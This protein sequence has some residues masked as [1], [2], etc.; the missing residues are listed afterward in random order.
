[1]LGNYKVALAMIG[2]FAFGA[3][4]QSLNAQ[5][6]PPAYGMLK[7]TSR[8]GR[9]LKHNF[10]LLLSKPWRRPVVVTLFEA[11]RQLLFKNCHLNRGS[12]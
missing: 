4:G 6:R 1:M 12:L 11:E 9:N 3:V 8:N 2:S 10:C 5:A 7:S